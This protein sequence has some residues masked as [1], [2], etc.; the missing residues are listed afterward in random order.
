MGKK[1]KR[2][3][4]QRD[5][6]SNGQFSGSLNWIH[7]DPAVNYEPFVF[8]VLCT[9][10][11]TKRGSRRQACVSYPMITFLSKTGIDLLSVITSRPEAN[12][13]YQVDKNEVSGIL[14]QE[15]SNRNG[16]ILPISGIGYILEETFLSILSRACL[17][18]L[19]L[20]CEMP[21]GRWERPFVIPFFSANFFIYFFI[22]SEFFAT[23]GVQ[24]LQSQCPHSGMDV[25]MCTHS[26]VLCVTRSKTQLP[27]VFSVFHASL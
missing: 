7:L 23:A 5:C 12:Y 8:H 14:H 15:S 26:A 18:F 1:A 4:G 16:A 9:C 20:F 27:S 6:V 19:F 17:C 10:I 22:F 3:A 11:S 13:T 24:I 25:H 2:R 21:P